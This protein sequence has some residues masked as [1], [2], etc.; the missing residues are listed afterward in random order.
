MVAGNAHSQVLLTI[1]LAEKPLNGFHY[2]LV[3]GVV[4]LTS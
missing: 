3:A 2:K 1:S 4:N